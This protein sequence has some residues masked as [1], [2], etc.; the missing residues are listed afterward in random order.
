VAWKRVRPEGTLIGWSGPCVNASN[1]GPPS[2]VSKSG[3]GPLQSAVPTA[4]SFGTVSRAAP[5]PSSGRLRAEFA[6]LARPRSMAAHHITNT[7]LRR[8]AGASVPI[9]LLDQVNGGT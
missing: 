3:L 5:R 2:Y 1:P 8:S 9:L 6:L 4:Q 7:I